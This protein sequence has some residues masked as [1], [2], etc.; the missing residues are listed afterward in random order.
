MFI[1]IRSYFEGKKLFLLT[2]APL[3][4]NIPS[5]HSYSIEYLN[6]SGIIDCIDRVN[7]IVWE[8]KCVSELNEKHKIQLLVYM[9]MLKNPKYDNYRFYLC[10]L[11]SG[12]IIEIYKCQFNDELFSKIVS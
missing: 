9:G 5:F 10:N 1:I 8:F 12:E 11:L 7:K 4:G 3:N 6:Y 2:G